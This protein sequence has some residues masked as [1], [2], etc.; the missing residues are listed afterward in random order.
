[1]EI[2]KVFIITVLMK[3]PTSICVCA[4]VCVCVYIYIY[5]YITSHYANLYLRPSHISVFTLRK[6]QALPKR[7][8]K[9]T[10]LKRFYANLLTRSLWESYD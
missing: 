1:M 7:R 5:I 4:C 6:T 9:F 2:T 10:F 8:I 3:S